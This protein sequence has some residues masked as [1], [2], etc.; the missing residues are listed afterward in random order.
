MGNVDGGEDK[1]VFQHRCINKKG[2]IMQ[3]VQ[4]F[5][6]YGVKCARTIAYLTHQG[7]S[8][9]S[10]F[11]GMMYQLSD[12]GVLE[13]NYDEVLPK[14]AALNAPGIMAKFLVSLHK[15]SM[16]KFDWIRICADALLQ[17]DMVPC[18]V[19]NWS[20]YG[21]EYECSE[22]FSAQLAALWINRMDLKNRLVI[23]EL[24]L[25]CCILL[26]LAVDC[27]KQSP[28]D[29]NM[30]SFNEMFSWMYR[31]C[32]KDSTDED[33]GIPDNK[34]HPEPIETYGNYE[35]KLVLVRRTI[36]YW[37]RKG[38]KMTMAKHFMSWK[39]VT[40]FLR[41][42]DEKEAKRVAEKKAEEEA[43]RRV[44]RSFVSPPPMRLRRSSD[45]ITVP[46]LASM[47][48]GVEEDLVPLVQKNKVSARLLVGC[49]RYQLRDNLDFRKRCSRYTPTMLVSLLGL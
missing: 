32:Y 31:S 30:P 2:E 16:D 40:I 25:H 12:T 28:K 47:L 9:G 13:G 42:Q 5:A 23:V 46:K 22:L 27:F 7:E 34:R 48:S 43:R 10:T 1:F 17:H 4:R 3:L 14:I 8:A 44:S 33:V 6:M 11:A 24:T 18:E 35:L 45:D 37:Q 20:V 15:P 39:W 26:R 49:C 38:E 21:K 36:E 41:V 29:T 19:M